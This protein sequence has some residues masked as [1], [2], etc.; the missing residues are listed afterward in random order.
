MYGA[1]V[2]GCHHKLEG[3]NQIQLLPAALRIFL[4]VGLCHP[5]ASLLMEADICASCLA[6]KGQMCC[7]LV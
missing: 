7:I 1:E 2:W 6:G 5:K 3:L 4:G